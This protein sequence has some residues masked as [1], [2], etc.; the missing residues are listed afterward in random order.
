MTRDQSR[1]ELTQIPGIGK[2]LATD[3]W[4]IGIK[5]VSDLSGEDPEMP[6]DL[7]NKFA[8]TVQDRC[9]LYAF[10]CAVYFASTPESKRKPE[11]LKWWNWK[12]ENFTKAS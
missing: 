2:S 1:T 3:L 5:Q 7:S 12:G 6:Y 4:N 10:R 11:K 9:I 8:C